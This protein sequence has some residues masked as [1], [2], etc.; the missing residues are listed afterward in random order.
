M[1]FVVWTREL[2]PGRNRL[3]VIHL[4]IFQKIDNRNACATNGAQA[5]CPHQ[6]VEL[7][8]NADWRPRYSALKISE[9][10]TMLPKMLQFLFSILAYLVALSSLAAFF[11]YIQ[12]GIDTIPPAFSWASIVYNILIF[13]VFPLQHS[14]LPR[15]RMKRWIQSHFDPLLERPLYVGS[16]GLA[17][18][19]V[20]W[21]WRPS[22]PYLY[23]MES[24]FLC[25]AIF[26]VAVLLIILSTVSLD[27]SSMFGLKQGYYAWK[28]IPFPEAGLKTTGIFGIVRHPITSLLI[29]ALWAQESMSMG[30]L[31]L[32]ILF[33]AYALIGT[34][35]EERSLL[36]DMKDEYES[37]KKRVPAFVPRVRTR[38]HTDATDPH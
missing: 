12:F 10:R 22:G 32:N 31:Q 17:M 2:L 1:S 11:W 15:R 3:K 16:S 36:Q 26:Y 30:R 34:V 38:M 35:I 4:N 37:Y 14:I 20:V 25:D 18:W 7:T 5:S 29:V 13:L 33:T 8:S 28:R 9:G 24:W 21:N 19:V 27:H 6:F 23:G